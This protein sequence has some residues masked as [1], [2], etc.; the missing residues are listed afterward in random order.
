M[1]GGK[2]TGALMEQQLDTGGGSPSPG[3]VH[4]GG[5]LQ[6]SDSGI[7]VKE[8]PQEDLAQVWETQ[9]QE[10]LNTVEMCPSEPDVP[11]LPQEPTPWEDAQAFLASFE[12]V[13]EACCW[14]KAEWVTRLLPALGG[15]AKQAFIKLEVEDREDYG[16]VKEAIL[17]G[18]AMSREK[19]RQHFRRF[20]YQE[21]E[22]PRG[23]YSQL[24]EL[25][26]RWLKVERHSKE[27]ILE[28][29]ILEQFLAVLPPEM[30]SWVRGHNLESSA[31]AVSLAEDYLLGQWVPEI[32]E[33]QMSELQEEASSDDGLQTGWESQQ[34]EEPVLP[35]VCKEE[36]ENKE[37]HPQESPKQMELRGKP[38]ERANDNGPQYCNQGETS[39]NWHRAERQLK[40]PIGQHLAEVGHKSM[41]CEAVGMKSNV[42]VPHQGTCNGKRSNACSLCGKTF[43]SHS[44]VLRHKRT[45][46]G[47]KP[48]RCS[49]CG[50]D[51]VSSEYLKTHQVSHAA[52]KPH[53]CLACGKGFSHKTSL[54][55]HQRTHAG[56]QPYQCADCGGSFA[57]L[58]SYQR[59]R[60]S[61]IGSEPVLRVCKAAQTEQGPICG[62]A[63]ADSQKL[64]SHQQLHTQEKS[65]QCTDCGERFRWKPALDSHAK[66]IHKGKHLVPLLR[67]I[68]PEGYRRSHER[69]KSLLKDT[70]GA[71]REK[72]LLPKGSDEHSKVPTCAECG[73]QFRKT[74][75]LTQHRRIHTGERP[76]QCPDCGQRFMWAASFYRHI[77]IHKAKKSVPLLPKATSKQKKSY[78]CSDC[79]RNFDRPSKVLRH[80]RVHTGEK[81]YQCT[82]C[83]ERFAWDLSLDNHRQKIHKVKKS[84]P[85]LPKATSKQKKPYTCSDC[86]RNFDRPS[87]VLRHQRVHTGE[88]PYQ[89]T[90]CGE[91]FAWDLSLD[92]HRQK[93]HKVKKSVPLLPKASRT[94]K[95]PYTCSGCEK[96]FASPSK[97]ARHQHVHSGEKPY[98]CTDC[99]KR[100]AWDVSLDKHRKKMHTAKKLVPPVQKVSRTPGKTCTC[101]DCGKSFGRYAQLAI[102]QRVH[103]GEKPFQ[104]RDCGQSFM[105][106]SALDRH[107]KKIHSAK[108]SVPPVQKVSGVQKKAIKCSECGKRFDKMSHLI[109]HQCLHTAEVPYK[110]AECG[111]SF[112]AR[113][114]FYRH[115]K[116][117]DGNKL[118]PLLQKV[119][120]MQRKSLTCSECGKSFDNPSSLVMHQRIHSGE[121]RY[122]CTECGERFM[123]GSSLKRH[124]EKFHKGK[125]MA[126][127]PQRGSRTPPKSHKCSE[128][129]KTFDRASRLLRHQHTHTKK[130]CYTC[131][132]CGKSF[133]Q[134]SSL[135]SHQ[136]IHAGEKLQSRKSFSQGSSLTS[137]QRIHTEEKLPQSSDLQNS[138]SRED[139]LASHKRS[140]GGLQHFSVKES[141]SRPLL[142]ISYQD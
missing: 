111:Q 104:C 40:A 28:L 119:S 116:I 129:G 13:A 142:L 117:H 11:G 110:C 45:H 5:S 32:R 132:E 92:N 19:Q 48:Y 71:M 15:E 64:R 96:I 65:Y 105:W 68:S 10:F 113:S 36:R 2:P 128:C 83:G 102:H 60:K 90:D 58:S 51:F 79:G 62:K 47:E 125:K 122:Q 50:K 120:G 59:H 31:Q 17:R 114:S 75:E 67:R 30:Q 91:R 39:E 99:G 70:E 1:A 124:R 74:R 100:F 77:K 9:W 69:E 88:K 23:V 44:S 94:Q 107:R 126:P 109:I 121:R 33:Q 38:P 89:C 138:A 8:E 73:K 49:Q 7:D 56:E 101:P 93:I 136:R 20:C 37:S 3:A 118:G 95:K 26:H 140:H 43:S 52:E 106:C 24:Q 63:F 41:L 29:L 127:L 72:I 76:Y 12:Q 133:S 66:Q 108:N 141:Q 86:G 123:W 14:P 53:K 46:T 18:D 34:E 115:K 78:P 84:V 54:Q 25:C 27:Q 42:T 82:D 61:H 137:H 87:K 139:S 134:R 4:A 130:R 81:P 6:S 57:S 131:S 135:T 80:Q 22:G 35:A 112:M 21:A 85:L 55:S 98:Q 103:T 16:K 97:L